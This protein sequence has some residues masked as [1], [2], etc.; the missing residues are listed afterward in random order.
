MPAPPAID[1]YQPSFLRFPIMNDRTGFKPV[2]LPVILIV[3][4][5]RNENGTTL[6]GTEVFDVKY[7]IAKAPDPAKVAGPFNTNKLIPQLNQFVVEL[8]ALQLHDVLIDVSNQTIIDTNG[9]TK[10][11]PEEGDYIQYTLIRGNVRSTIPYFPDADY[12]DLSNIEIDV[13]DLP[14]P[15]RYH[16]VW[17]ASYNRRLIYDPT[18]GAASAYCISEAVAITQYNMIINHPGEVHHSMYRK[19]PPL[20]FDEAQN[21]FQLSNDKVLEFYRPFAD[22]LQDIFDEQTFLNG[23][24]HI[25]QIPAQLIPYL[26]YL[27]GWDLPN[28]PGASDT[29]R[30]SILRHAVRLQQLK[31][32]KRAIVELFDIFGYTIDIINLWYSTD[33]TRLIAPDETLPTILQGEQISANTV[34]QIEPL[35]ADYNTDGFG[36]FEVPLVYRPNGDFTVT[37]YLVQNGPTRNV[38][39]NIVNEITDD[40]NNME[41]K[42]QRT[43]GNLMPKGITDRIPSTDATLIAYSDVYMDYTSGTGESTSSSTAIPIINDLGVT[44]NKEQNTLSVNL[45]H[46]TG[47]TEDETKL[48]IFVTYPR[49][50]IDVPHTLDNLRSNRFDVRILLRDGDVPAPTMFEF[51]LNFVFKLKAFHSLLRKIIYRINFYEVYNVQDHCYGPDNQLQVP[52]AVEPVSQTD[53]ICNEDTITQGYKTSDLQI[54]QSIFDSLLDNFLSWKEL[55]NSNRIEEELNRY[56]NL[57]VNGPIGQACQYTRLGQDRISSIPDT[58]LDHNP[59][60]RAQVC[61]ENQAEPNSCFK[62]RVKDNLFVIPDLLLKEVVRCKPCPLG[63]GSGYYWMYPQTEQSLLRDGFGSYTGQYSASF[64]GKKIRK[65]NHPTQ[66]LHYTNRPYLFDGQQESDRLLAYQRP[67]LD[68]QKDNMAFPSHK[69]PHMAYIKDDF[70]HPDWYAKPWDDV[71]EDLNVVKVVGSDGDEYLEFDEADIVYPG[72]GLDPDISSF[73]SHEVR[74]YVV[75]HKVYQTAEAGHA[76][77]TLDDQVVLTEDESIEFDSSLPFGPIFESYNANC[78]KDYIS[79]YPAVY[80]RQDVSIDFEFDEDGGTDLLGDGLGLS[81]LDGTSVDVLFLFG[82]QILV[83]S[84]DRDYAYWR[85]YRYDCACSR[86]GCGSDSSSGAL[87]G[88]AS[89]SELTAAPEG[90]LNVDQCHISLYQQPDGKLDFNCDQ[91]SLD[92]DGKWTES[93]GICSTMFDGSIENMICILSGGDVPDGILPEGSVYWKDDYD[94][95]HEIAWVY[96]GDIIDILTTTKSPHVWGEEDTG[97]VSGYQV[98]RRGI[99]TSVRQIIRINDDGTYE[100]RGEGSSQ[101]VDYFRTNVLCGEKPFVDNFCYHYDCIMSDKVDTQMVCGPR[102][103][104]CEDDEVQ[105]PSLV[106]DSAGIVQGLE[107]PENIQPFGWI[108]AWGNVEA[109][110]ITGVCITDFGTEPV[111]DLTFEGEGGEI[112]SLNENSGS[113]PT[114]MPHYSFMSELEIS[115]DRRIV[116]FLSIKFVDFEHTFSGD[117]HAVLFSPLGVPAVTIFHRPGSTNGSFG[118]FGDFNGDYTF[119]NSSLP[120]LTDFGNIASGAYSRDPGDWPGGQVPVGSFDDFKNVRTRG[121][122]KLVIYDWAGGDVGSLGSWVMRLRTTCD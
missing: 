28:Y 73:G 44:Y 16:F 96:H 67:S 97:Y 41:D 65:Y 63:M 103:V 79:G 17:Q 42:C 1:R 25:D 108:N 12:Y 110:D 72:N 66:S 78:N 95:I 89:S 64:L 36:E 43:N 37:A 8:N 88:L 121:T 40:P 33:L 68:V 99:I 13:E 80:G 3:P 122:W 30:R 22:M 45:D 31:G 51:L 24:N 2:A 35:V 85:P 58:D 47:F 82:S 111:V 4:G 71:D 50:K 114:L 116:E 104:S 7:F 91:L 109:D 117:L 34:C 81:C 46:Y 113:W 84:S 55:D 101:V 32:S 90:V 92:V 10:E 38:L 49:V 87:A 86:Y 70:T 75:T 48:F 106:T 52:P 39:N 112:P 21:S 11:N 100:I 20:Y 54:R 94:V 56:L 18:L 118:N 23:I 115:L 60:T 102:W 98:F 74:N 9:N 6:A 14:R 83:E 105:W 93:L 57:A 77:L 119:F 15:H 61:S 59:D 107:V 5:R 69:F 27:I 120:L 53:D 29:I 62:G 26:A 19:T 76:S